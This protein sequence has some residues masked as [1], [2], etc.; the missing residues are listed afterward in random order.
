MLHFSGETHPLCKVTITHTVHTRVMNITSTASSI[1]R[2]VSADCTA[3]SAL[4]SEHS[5]SCSELSSGMYCRVKN[6]RPTCVPL[7]RQSTIILHGS[8]S[9]KTILNIILAAVRTWNL[10]FSVLICI[11]TSQM[12][13]CSRHNY[14]QNMPRGLNRQP[15]A[16]DVWLWFILKYKVQSCTKR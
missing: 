8:T 3:V 6:C 5:V 11:P 12:K 2:S 16:S 13:I 9:Q 15:Y 4:P 1:C 7:K 10:T 14:D